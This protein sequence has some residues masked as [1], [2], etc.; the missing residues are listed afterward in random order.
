[1]AFEVA[2]FGITVNTIG[3]G[4]IATEAS[5]NWITQR[6]AELGS[7]AKELRARSNTNVPMG[8]Q[9]TVEEISSLAVYLCSVQAGYTTGETIL[10][11]GGIVNCIV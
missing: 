2:P 10:C 9:G 5:L 6:A 4:T 1:M 3:T 11:D 7:T 8:R